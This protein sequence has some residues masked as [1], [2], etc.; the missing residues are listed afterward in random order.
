MLGLVFNTLI[1]TDKY[2]RHNRENFPQAIQ[3]QLSKKPKTFFSIFYCT[4]KIYIRFWTFLKKD[5]PQSLGIAEIVQSDKRVSVN[6]WKVL[7]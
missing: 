2:S 4:S 1:A 6:V 7:I 3:T 5:K